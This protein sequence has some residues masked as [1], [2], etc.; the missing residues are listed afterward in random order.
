MPKR[1]QKPL[2]TYIP[3]FVQYCKEIGL[4]EKT[5]QNYANSLKNFTNWIQIT[6]NTGLKPYEFDLNRAKEYKNY[7]SSTKLS[8]A[9]KNHYLIA[10]R[11]FLRYLS[12]CNINSLTP[13]KIT[14]LKLQ[15]PSQN[16]T[17][18]EL[19]QIEKLLSLPDVNTEIGL[20]DRTILET[21]TFTGLKV[22][23][24]I[25]LE[26]DINKL[27]SVINSRRAFVWI[28][29]YL[30]TRKDNHKPVF[31]NYRGRKTNRR[32]TA[33]SIERI[34]SR[35]GKR[36]NLSYP[37]TPEILRKSYVLALIKE[38]E[39][40]KINFP[41]TQ[42]IVVQK[43]LTPSLLFSRSSSEDEEKISPDSFSSWYTIEKVINKEI[44]WLKN[45]ILLLPEK[46]P[47]NLLP[48]QVP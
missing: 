31:I 37:L 47:K 38:Q 10:L 18:L 16:N 7:L 1:E 15:K 21:I 2:I 41:F 11:A 3:S 35:Y 36:I 45:N 30:K 34:V 8:S 26:R 17:Y 5:Q 22:S 23:K 9:T 43:Y 39:K 33:R 24:L 48:Y 28:Q 32:L 19:T 13:E 40:I 27:K 29:K 42:K 46:Y 14:L 25:Q 20:R 12:V 4:S 6:N 44:S